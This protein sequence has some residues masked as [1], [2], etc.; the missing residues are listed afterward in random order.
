MLPAGTG[1][2]SILSSNVSGSG[3]A[4]AVATAGAFAFLAVS[5]GAG[6]AP[7]VVVSI[8]TSS[9]LANKSDG[10]AASSVVTASCVLLG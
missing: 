6:F 1:N 2:I 5:A 8:F 3:L 7:V 9:F 10:V 4:V